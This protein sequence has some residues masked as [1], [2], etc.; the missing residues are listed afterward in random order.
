MDLLDIPIKDLADLP[1]HVSKAL[2][3][4]R[5]DINACIK[6]F[7]FQGD[8]DTCAGLRQTLDLIDKALRK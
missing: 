2:R 5:I 6:L 1:P 7:E 8:G 4:A 3:H